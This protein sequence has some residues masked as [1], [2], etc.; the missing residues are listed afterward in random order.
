[1][2]INPKK[3]EPP[4]AQLAVDSLPWAVFWL[5]DDGM[6]LHA[7]DQA[8]SLLGFTYEELTARPITKIDLNSRSNKQPADRYSNSEE[9]TVFET[10]LEHKNGATINVEVTVSEIEVDRQRMRCAFARDISNQQQQQKQTELV[11]IG[12]DDSIAATLIAQVDRSSPNKPLLVIYTNDAFKLMSGYGDETE[13]AN[14]PAILAGVE[15][16]VDLQQIIKECINRRQPLRHEILAYNKHGFKFWAELGLSPIA[17]W[18]DKYSYWMI[19]Y[20]DITNRKLAEKRLS[21]L[22]DTLNLEREL[23]QQSNADLEQFAYVASHDLQE[24]L[25][26]VSGFMELL[27]Q[28]Y[29]DQLD[30]KARGY[31]S[32]SIDGAARLEQLIGDLL[33]FSRVTRDDSDLGEVDL[34]KCVL[35][36]QKNLERLIAET[37]ASIEVQELPTIMG[38][39]SQLKQLVQNLIENGIKYRSDV[40]PIVRISSSTDGEFVELRVS[41]N[42]IGI[43]PE[44]REQVFTLFKRL[45][46]REE[47]K[48]TGIGLAICHRVAQR[49]CGS[50]NIEESVGGGTCFV[51]RLLM[52]R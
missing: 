30:E 45:H 4:P 2:R 16:D 10:L 18:S 15:T 26:A 32:K 43:K 21:E 37:S 38:V 28:R 5:A 3:P 36:A 20:R 23:L 46:R 29:S 14:T 8:S 51:V 17:K 22:K 40:S 19:T 1:M 52:Q 49:H 44:F 50:I 25:R 48:G 34:N 47:Y 33:H 27:R 35:N 42:G 6:I 31:I 12:V 11:N 13:L 41:D 9:S 39:E 7:N 24:P